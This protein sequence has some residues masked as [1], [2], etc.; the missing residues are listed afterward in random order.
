MRVALFSDVHG[1]DIALTTVCRVPID[2]SAVRQAVET[3][4]RPIRAVLLEAYAEAG[5]PSGLPS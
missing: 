1:S 3:A 5:T 2:R 4:E